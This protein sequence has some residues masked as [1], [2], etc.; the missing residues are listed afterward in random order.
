MGCVADDDASLARLGQIGIVHADCIVADDLEL[1]TGGI[2][3]LG[4]DEGVGRRR[5]HGIGP[6]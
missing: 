6:P 2:E 3:K 1:R 4:V 5:Q